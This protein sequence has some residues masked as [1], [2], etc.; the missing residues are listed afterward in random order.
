[1]VHRRFDAM[2]DITMCLIGIYLCAC[3]VVGFVVI[4]EWAFKML[5]SAVEVL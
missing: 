4:M 1:M 5:L 3:C 2:R